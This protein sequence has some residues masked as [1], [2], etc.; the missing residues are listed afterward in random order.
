MTLMCNGHPLRNTTADKV[1]CATCG[2]PIH[3]LEVD[4]VETLPEVWC[5]QWKKRGTEGNPEFLCALKSQPKTREPP[6]YRDSMRTL[7]NHYVLLTTGIVKAVPTC[8]DCL[9]KM[10]K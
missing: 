10:N 7:C 6:H 1:H 9:N 4:D 5:V 2:A 8:P 3:P